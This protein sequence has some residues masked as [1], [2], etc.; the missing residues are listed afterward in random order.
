MYVTIYEFIIYKLQHLLAYEKTKSLENVESC[1][2]LKFM[3]LYK[4]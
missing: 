1:E 2:S 4:S 3:A